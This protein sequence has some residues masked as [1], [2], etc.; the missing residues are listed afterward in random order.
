MDLA[1]VAIGLQASANQQK[2]AISQIKQNAQVQ[3]QIADVVS[4]G[5]ATASA[6]ARGQI[7]DLSV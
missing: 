4:K 2:F 7:V 1:S 6:S 3:Q 5:A